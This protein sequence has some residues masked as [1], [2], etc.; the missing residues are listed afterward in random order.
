MFSTL[1][2]KEKLVISNTTFSSTCLSIK[3]VY[4]IDRSF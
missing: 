1:K 3:T 2:T 4:F